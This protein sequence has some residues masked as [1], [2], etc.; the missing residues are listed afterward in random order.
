MIID[1]SKILRLRPYEVA[2]CFPLARDHPKP[3]THCGGAVRLRNANEPS[4]PHLLTL[5]CTKCN[6]DFA[7]VDVLPE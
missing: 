5:S 3:C 6:E 2:S 7:L 4:M 1:T